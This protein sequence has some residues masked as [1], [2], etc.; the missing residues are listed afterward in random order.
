[1]DLLFVIFIFWF[2][3]KKS[4]QKNIASLQNITK[5]LVQ[6]GFHSISQLTQNQENQILTALLNGDNYLICIMRPT[7]NVY[8]S[9]V[10][11][12]ISL[13]QKNHYHNIILIAPHIAISNS[14]KPLIAENK[15]K[16]WDYE[17]LRKFATP[18]PKHQSEIIQTSEIHD[19]CQISSSTDPIQ[20]GRHI[21]S[22][23]G[24][25]FNKNKIERL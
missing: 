1:M 6:N 20:D 17:K 23:F 12:L 5:I 14:A 2:I 4:A 13:A 15:I 18:N 19:T 22:L 8:N 16:V 24:N 3:F 7:A 11:N 10:Q 25:L 21:N 9:T